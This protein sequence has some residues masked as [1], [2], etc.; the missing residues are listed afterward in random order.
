[1]KLRVENTKPLTNRTYLQVTL[2]IIQGIKHR[3]K[4]RNFINTAVILFETLKL[5]FRIF[6][7]PC[8]NFKLANINSKL[9]TSAKLLLISSQLSVTSTRITQ[10]H[11]TVLK[12]LPRLFIKANSI[13]D[14]IYDALKALPTN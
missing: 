12:P 7:F 6:K 14:H 11:S 2:K 5:H 3:L 8:V 13:V 9:A 4:T 1:M 10:I